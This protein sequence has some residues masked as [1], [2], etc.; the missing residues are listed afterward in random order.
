[1]IL[2]AVSLA[3][4]ERVLLLLVEVVFY[5]SFLPVSAMQ[6]QLILLFWQQVLKRLFFNDEYWFE[7]QTLL[8]RGREAY[9]LVISSPLHPSNIALCGNSAVADLSFT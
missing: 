5:P 2:Q 7:K 8:G 4:I 3:L 9:K 6:M 1:M